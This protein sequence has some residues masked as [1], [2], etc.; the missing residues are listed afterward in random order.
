MKINPESTSEVDD[1]EHKQAMS[2]PSTSTNRGDEEEEF[3]VTQQQ[4]HPAPAQYGFNFASM[5]NQG[6]LPRYA[7]HTYCDFSTYI[8]KGGKIERHKKSDRNFPA[9]LHAMLSDERY[10]HIISWMVS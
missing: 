2:S 5:P 10:S 6:V 1:D 9:R 8:E 4:R 3:D 7:D